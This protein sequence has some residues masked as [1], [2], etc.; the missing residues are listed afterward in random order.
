MESTSPQAPASPPPRRVDPLNKASYPGL[1]VMLTVA[2]VRAAADFY[3]RAFGFEVR[4]FMRGPDGKH[5]HGELTIRGTHLMLTPAERGARTARAVGHSP[6]IMYLLVEDV[7]KVVTEAVRLGGSAMGKVE[8]MFWGDRRGH[9]VDPDGHDWLI[10]THVDDYSLRQ[11]QK[12]NISFHGGSGACFV[13][14]DNAVDP[15]PFAP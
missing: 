5:I 14:V 11:F 4:G 6:A 1:T 2:D 3:N 12:V 8:D 10:A 15:P 9:I 13:Q 7:D